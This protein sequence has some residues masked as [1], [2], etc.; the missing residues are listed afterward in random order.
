MVSCF[1]IFLLALFL[2]PFS[3]LVTKFGT[4]VALEL[5]ETFHVPWGGTD[6]PGGYTAPSL[7]Y[8]L[9]MVQSTQRR[10][11]GASAFARS[12]AYHEHS[13]LQLSEESRAAYLEDGYL[14]M[15]KA[16]PTETVANLAKYAIKRYGT[17]ATTEH[18]QWMHDDALLD[19][20][21]FGPFGYIASQ[22]MGGQ[23]AYLSNLHQFVSFNSPS[24]VQGYHYDLKECYDY[25]PAREVESIGVKFFVPL[26]D[27][28][29]PWVVKQTTMHSLKDTVY[30]DFHSMFDALNETAV[31]QANKA[32]V[33]APV[34]VR[35]KADAVSTKPFLNAGD[36]VLHSPC[37]LHGSPRDLDPFTL[38][39]FL[40]PTYAHRSTKISPLQKQ[41][42]TTGFY[43]ED[44]RIENAWQP[45]CYPLAYPP[46]P[47]AKFELHRY[48]HN[49]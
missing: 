19:F 41:D 4:L 45:W 31:K 42:C 12:T 18:L 26:T 35:D 8:R 10:T 30:A 46:S 23:D 13:K 7:A 24:P 6:T 39:G 15:R 16:L 38:R 34:H 49:G 11:L 21:I 3:S 27:M 14:L 28:P 9:S 40:C 44:K 47:P 1:L 29:G 17:Q 25:K 22:L 32:I 36:I 33:N 20:L 37:I 48:M 5:L 43:S 2:V